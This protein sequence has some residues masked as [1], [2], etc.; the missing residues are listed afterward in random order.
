VEVSKWTS[1]N[2]L[3]L[4]L[5]G[6]RLRYDA[7][8]EWGV[9]IASSRC[10]MDGQDSTKGMVARGCAKFGVSIPS[11]LSIFRRDGKALRHEMHMLAGEWTDIVN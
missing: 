7:E 9:V 2:N 1:V 11:D 5:N 6:R 8:I 4:K 3:Q 10:C